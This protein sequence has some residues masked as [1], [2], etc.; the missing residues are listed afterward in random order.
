MRYL[1]T[2]V[3]CVA[4]LAPVA[5]IAAASPS[6]AAD[7]AY[8]VDTQLHV[9]AEGGT[10]QNS[11]QDSGLVQAGAPVVISLTA[12]ASGA[13]GASGHA[14]GTASSFYGALALSG[15]GYAIPGAGPP[16]TGAGAANSAVV[17]GFP[18]DYFRDQISVQSNT[19][20]AGTA[21]NIGFT[22]DYSGSG[23]FVSESGG[24]QPSK[25]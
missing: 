6:Q 4:L 7:P 16:P 18:N 1:K 3:R 19:L 24:L 17:G 8:A 22:I 10:A 14:T 20:A 25:A 9:E 5:A 13:A 12:D 21:V 2:L 15:S 23:S 11:S